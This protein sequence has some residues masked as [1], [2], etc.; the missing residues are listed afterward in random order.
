MKQ[1]VIENPV[2]N[3]PFSEPKRHFR[4][5]DESITNDIVESRRVSS[6]FIPIAKP[7]KKGRQLTF[8]TE[9]TK[10]RVQE[11]KFINQI[12][13]RVARWRS[14]GNVGI[15]KTAARLLEYWQRPDRERRLFFCQIEAL[16][17][18]I[19]LTEVA[20]YVTNGWLFTVES[21]AGILLGR[22]ELLAGLR[23]LKNQSPDLLDGFR[24]GLRIWY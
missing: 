8:E 21:S 7:K 14:G 5:S 22:V 19:Y 10:E 20:A 12:R 15:S 3:S 23:I 11:N 16:E 2:L 18:A 1:V 17:T 13:E 4:F 6:Y 24:V 9:W